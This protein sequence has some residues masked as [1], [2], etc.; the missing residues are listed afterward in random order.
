MYFLRLCKNCSFLNYRFF[1]LVLLWLLP[2]R[3][4]YLFYKNSSKYEQ[5]CN[6]ANRSSHGFMTANQSRHDTQLRTIFFSIIQDVTNRWSIYQKLF[7][8][9]MYSRSESKSNSQ[10]VT[11]ASNLIYKYKYNYVFRLEEKVLSMGNG[12]FYRFPYHHTWCAFFLL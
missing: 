3:K 9:I 10:T 5:I 12:S 1:V 2:K 8:N 4:K 11:P 7:S 6:N